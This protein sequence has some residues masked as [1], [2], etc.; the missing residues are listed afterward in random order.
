MQHKLF[1]NETN[2]S[3]HKLVDNFSKI[4]GLHEADVDLLMREL[5]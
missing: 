3:Q 5:S 4:F 1:I 2:C